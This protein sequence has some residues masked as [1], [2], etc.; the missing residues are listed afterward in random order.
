MTFSNAIQIWGSDTNM[1]IYEKFGIHNFVILA[2]YKKNV[3]EDFFVKP[4]CLHIC[5]DCFLPIP[6]ICCIATSVFLCSD[7]SVFNK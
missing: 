2:G 1:G 3:I 4:I 5:R 7:I 6:N